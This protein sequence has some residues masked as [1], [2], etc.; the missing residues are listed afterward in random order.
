MISATS[1]D[2]QV[3]RRGFAIQS[4]ICLWV[5]AALFWYAARFYPIL[6]PVLHRTFHHLWH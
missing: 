6:R 2:N 1:S 3:K 4:T 5:V